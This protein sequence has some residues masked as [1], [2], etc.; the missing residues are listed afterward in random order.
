MATSTTTAVEETTGREIVTTRLISAPRE[1]VWKVWTDPKHM[2]KW[3]GPDG[4]TTTT[5]KF[6]FRPGGVWRHV[7]HG[8]DGRDYPNE[9]IYENIEEPESI[10]YSQSG[11]ADAST[12]VHF[13]ST[14]TFEDQGEKT[15]VTMKALFANAAQLEYVAKNYGAI[16]GA[17]QHLARLDQYAQQIMK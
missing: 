1:L 8:P 10:S 12:E 2:A 5:S 7:M 9:I 3:W 13:H 4:F 6:E 11:D 16:E 14:V 15:L 17:V